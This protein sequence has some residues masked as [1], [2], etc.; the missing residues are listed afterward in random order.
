MVKVRQKVIAVMSVLVLFLSS[1]PAVFA[2][3]V[4]STD[5]NNTPDSGV[6]G[7]ESMT[8]NDSEILDFRTYV[9]NYKNAEKPNDTI[10]VDLKS[11]KTSSKNVYWYDSLSYEGDG[12]LYMGDN[13]S[14]ALPFQVK[15]TGLY[16]IEVVYYP[17]EGKGSS[18]VRE[19]RIDGK[20]PFSE[21]QNLTFTRVFKNASEIKTDN[22]GNQIRPQQEESPMWI[23]TDLYDTLGY[24]S[25]PLQF[26]LEAGSHELEFSSIREPMLIGMI[27]IY[28]SPA[29]GSYK[30]PEN[31]TS[32]ETGYIKI[33]GE[34]AVLKSDSQLYPLSDSSTPSTVPNDPKKI[35]LNT[36]GGSKWHSNGQWLQWDFNIKTAGYYKIGIKFRQ[37]VT[38][39]QSSYRKIYIDGKVPFSELKNVSFSYNNRWQYKTLG[40]EEE[41]YYIYLD[42]GPHTIKMQV[43]LGDIA[44]LAQNVNYS[45]TRLNDIYRELLMIIGQDPDKTRDYQFKKVAPDAVKGLGDES[46]TL[47]NYY[48]QFVNMNGMGGNQAQILKNIADLTAKM[49]KN[50]DK[51]AK[52]FSTFS[53]YISSL[54]TWLTTAMN[55]SLEIDY[56]ELATPEFDWESP[57]ASFTEYMSFILKQFIASFFVDYNS[58][59]QSTTSDKSI[60]VWLS[61][62]RDQATALNQLIMNDFTAK[63]HIGVN[64][65]LVASSNQM[66]SSNTLLTATL[67]NKGPDIALSLEQSL[68]M[69][70][71]IRGAVAD[72]TQFPDY[73]EVL[74]RF[75]KSAVEPLWFNGSL[76]GLPETQTFYMLFYR[77]DILD[78]L[79]LDVPQT[80]EDVLAM[81]P[82]LQK[83][84][85]NFGLPLPM[86]TTSTGIGLPMFTTLLYQYGGKLYS[87][88]GSKSMLDSIESSKA[89][90]FWTAFYSDYS[91]PDSYN[92]I[93]RF[94]AGSI[95]IG[96]ADYGTYNQLSVF[97]PELDGIWNFAEI[98]G[99]QKEDGS[100]DRTVAST[101]TACVIMNS[102]K[103]IDSSWEF[104]KWWTSTDVQVQYGNEL[105]SILGTAGRYQTANVEAMYSIPWS[106][107]DFNILSKQ[108]TKTKGI[109]EVPGS[110]M[111]SRYVDFAFKQVVVSK[112]DNT[113]KVILD[114]STLINTE[115]TEKRREF[116]LS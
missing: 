68:P 64:L 110:Y 60:S 61:T 17:I 88:D 90:N 1:A 22:S 105:E 5:S 84:N 48:K 4:R 86:S 95:P 35:L 113:D 38:P 70:Y 18:I 116:N 42:K 49:S 20:L 46:K 79:N 103:D 112:D 87:E 67:A 47:E 50:P 63:H 26:Y 44:T 39:G 34:D 58:I 43:V 27:T 2:D 37:N 25:E 65:Q 6:T 45:I 54:G 82:V 59:G 104:L 33:Q 28:Q 77:S 53:N 21:C 115:L 94:R 12:S 74:K 78:E 57:N 30:K 97:A 24:Y 76:Y 93:T 75:Q 81:L 99:F 55:Q 13:D 102:T 108:W 29:A 10:V 9:T 83:K 85:L 92:F 7:S 41:P 52:Y 89:F 71:A 15:K 66:V 11:F 69:N 91:L 73:K 109:P 114:I 101:V 107:K 100:I 3:D 16:N 56:I 23:K 36:I 98:P 19:L 40:T 72:L 8:S 62:G 51:I 14:V 80:W 31:V 96:I 106:T 111:T 32:T